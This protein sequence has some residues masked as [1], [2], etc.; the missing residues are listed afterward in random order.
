MSKYQNK[1]CTIGGKVFDSV[2]EGRRY[3]YLLSIERAGKISDLRCQVPFELLPVQRAESTVVYK[4]GKRKGEAKPGCVIESAVKYI[5]DFVYVQDGKTV[6]E[7]VKGKRT[8][9]YIIK[10]KLMLYVHKIKIREV[11]A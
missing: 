1:S 11:S 3:I 7:D 8:K 9:D 10:R 5:A 6:V 2:A 4:R